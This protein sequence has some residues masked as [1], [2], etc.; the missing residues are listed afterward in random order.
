MDHMVT[1]TLSAV[2]KSG[3]AHGMDVDTPFFN[4]LP[5]I[6]EEATNPLS[7]L[8]TEYRQQSYVT[9]YFPSIHVNYHI[10]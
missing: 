8:G 9:K 1:E 2:K 7:A 6:I 10:S 4:N 3:K 5:S